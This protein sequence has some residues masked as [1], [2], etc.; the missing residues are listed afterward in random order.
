MYDLPV[1]AE[2]IVLMNEFEEAALE[3]DL[4][5]IMRINHYQ[6][7]VLSSIMTVCLGIFFFDFQI[8][9]LAISICWGYSSAFVPRAFRAM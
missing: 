2:F 1:F 7:P 8:V 3:D 5:S 4:M 6:R 9:S